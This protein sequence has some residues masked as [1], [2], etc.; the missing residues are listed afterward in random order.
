[1]DKVVELGVLISES[2]NLDINY[3]NIK[4][5][6]EVYK[7]RTPLNNTE[8]KTNNGNM[9]SR[10]YTEDGINEPQFQKRLK[11]RALYGECDHPTRDNPER[12]LQVYNKF[13]SHLFTD[14]WFEGN[15]LMSDVE[16]AKSKYGKEM[17]RYLEQ[18]SIPA[19]SLRA[20]GKIKRLPNGE[21]EKKLKIVTWDWVYDASVDEAWADTNSFKT[22]NTLNPKDEGND[23]AKKLFAASNVE[24]IKGIFKDVDRDLELIA[25]SFEGMVPEKIIYTP[26][27]NVIGYYSENVSAY[28]KIQNKLKKEL[29]EFMKL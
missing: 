10:K 9:F 20:A 12:Y 26:Q 29:N 11:N 4:K 17:C 5:T 14:L 13:R 22:H 24:S 3:D 25:E 21:K 1:M 23:V 2:M 8:K 28:S 19:F 18:R 16:T 7:F 15:L 27:N 6:N